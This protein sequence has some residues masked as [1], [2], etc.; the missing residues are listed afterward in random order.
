MPLYDQLEVMRKETRRLRHFAGR[1][2]RKINHPAVEKPNPLPPDAE[3]V[4]VVESPSPLQVWPEPPPADYLGQLAPAFQSGLAERWKSVSLEDCFFYHTVRIPDG[5]FIEG[6]WNLIG[7]EDTYLGAVPLRG[8]RVLELGPATGWL[9]YW[10]EKQGAKVVGLDLGWDL[11]PDLLPLSHINIP[12]MRKDQVAFL[13][14]VQ[15]AWW[16]LHR[17]YNLSAQAVYGSIYDLPADLGSFDVVVFGSI[18]LHLKDPFQALQE[19]A[20]RTTGT[21]IVAEPS[22]FDSQ[23]NLRPLLRFN[24]TE[25]VN[26]NGWWNSSPGVITDML[27]LLGFTDSTVTYHTQWYLP[28]AGTNAEHAVAPLYTVVARR[29]T[30]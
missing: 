22:A 27:G 21:I 18:L 4:S 25:G 11:A 14:R 6:P 9:T 1:I 7:N 24:P 15:N 20:E 13:N 19:A 30:A 5:R 16:Y 8:R 17:E 10:M 12:Q 29:G 28:E 2:K 3:L 26:P 23:D